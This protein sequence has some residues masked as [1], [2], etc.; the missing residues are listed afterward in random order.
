MLAWRP[1]RDT[2][3]PLCVPGT[4]CG[5]GCMSPST[6]F[7]T[8]LFPGSLEPAHWDLPWTRN[9]SCPGFV[10]IMVLGDASPIAPG[11]SQWV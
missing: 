2:A 3:D 9:G 7:C 11:S 10:F 6:G 8:L 4:W 5:S 1:M